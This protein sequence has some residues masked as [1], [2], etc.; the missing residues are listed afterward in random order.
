[1]IGPE[2]FAIKV[3]AI[4]SEGATLIGLKEFAINVYTI[5]STIL[6]SREV[7]DKL[8]IINSETTVL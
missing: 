6:W 7:G 5:K 2:T 1:M 3:Y 8:C 4:N